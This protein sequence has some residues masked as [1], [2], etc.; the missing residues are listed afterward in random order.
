MPGAEYHRGTSQPALNPMWAPAATAVTT[1]TICNIS[2][3]YSL[4]SPSVSCSGLGLSAGL[5]ACLSSCGNP[6]AVFSP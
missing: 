4:P 1:D 3:Y 2:R 5:P 6:S